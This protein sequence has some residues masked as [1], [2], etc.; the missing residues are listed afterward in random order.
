MTAS[1]EGPRA[2]SGATARSRFGRLARMA[3]GDGARAAASG[4]EHHPPA[5]LIRCLCHEVAVGPRDLARA[6]PGERQEAAEQDRTDRMQGQVHPRDDAQAGTVPAQRPQQVGV[7]WIGGLHRAAVGEEHLCSGEAG[8]R[9][10]ECPLEPAAPPGENDPG[11]PEPGDP[12]TG[13][14]EPV[15]LRGR[16][17]GEPRRPAGDVCRPGLHVD[18]DGVHRREVEDQAVVEDRAGRGRLRPARRPGAHARRRTPAH[19]RCPQRNDSSQSPWAAG[20]RGRR[21]PRG[22]PRRADHPAR[23]PPRR[24]GRGGRRARPRIRCSGGPGPPGS[25]R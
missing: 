23:R 9:R 20:R 11:D 24:R 16:V 7:A 13:R 8:A 12:R 6:D 3:E 18:R 15:Q 5:H 10:P 17:E 4:E 14:G 19:R 25:P 22:D 2:R 1:S 21:R